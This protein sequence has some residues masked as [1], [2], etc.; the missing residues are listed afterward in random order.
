MSLLTRKDVIIVA[1]VSCIYGLGK[2]QFY[3]DKK[4]ALKTGQKINRQELLHRLVSM[5]YR[6]NDI[7]FG[8]GTFRVKGDVIDI[9]PAYEDE[10]II[11]L[12]MFGDEIERI[13]K[14]NM[15]T[16]KPVGADSHVGSENQR[17]GHMGSTLHE[18]K[19][20]PNSHYVMPEGQNDRIIS[21]IKA[22][23]KIRLA[24]FKKHN[25]LLEAQRLKQ[26][27]QYDLEMLEHTGTVA[28][29]ENY[30]RYLDDRKPG[31]P[32]EVLIDYFPKDFLMI[33]DESHISIPQVRGMYFG[34]L[35]RKENLV[36]Y[37]FRLPSAKD[38]R[39]LKFA[40]FENHY[41][42]NFL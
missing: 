7:D 13:S 23:L 20:Y 32:S 27:V 40:E 36:D 42:Q 35:A 24:E 11:K 14:V 8:R 31:E 3:E 4:L 16:G 34:D 5:N 1:S 18:I 25:R 9:F 39:P 29:I 30:S 15:L 22:D 2:K 26:R 6:R 37:G 21:E 33:I 17:G 10:T 41:N 12:E 28:G 38:N 19:I